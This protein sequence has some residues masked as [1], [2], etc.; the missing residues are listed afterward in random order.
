MLI[1]KSESR[2]ILIITILSIVVPLL[3]AILLF[4]PTKLNVEGNW[5]N[6]LPHIIGTLNS[7]TA[8]ALLFGFWAIKNNKVDYHRIAMTVAFL[9]GILFLVFYVIYHSGAESTIYG[10]VNK[11]GLL[12]DIEREALGQSRIIYLIILLSHIV[13]ATIVVPFVLFAIYYGYTSNWLKHKKIVK[14]TLP[15][16]LY[17]SITGVIVYLMIRQYY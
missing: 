14:F 7:A 6:Y 17:V 3:V 11:D 8:I 5:I 13:L 4:M 1:S 15:I 10:D 12:S 9:L 2:N 16:W